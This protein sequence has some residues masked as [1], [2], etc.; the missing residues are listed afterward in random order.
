MFWP[1]KNQVI[2]LNTSKNVGFWGAHG[3]LY[4]GSNLYKYL[5]RNEHIDPK[6][7]FWVD[8]FWADTLSV[9]YLSSLEGTK[10][11][12]HTSIIYLV[13]TVRVPSFQP[14]PPPESCEM[15]L[16]EFEFQSDRGATWIFFPG[17]SN[18]REEVH[19]TKIDL[20]QLG[21][22]SGYGIFIYG[23]AYALQTT[24]C[25][26]HVMMVG[27]CKVICPTFPSFRHE[28]VSNPFFSAKYQKPRI[29]KIHLFCRDI[30]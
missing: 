10:I 13:Y 14:P 9:G 3:T 21:G 4:K 22:N 25:S 11:C 2:T 12:I 23:M 17:T 18:T 5:P 24:F 15:A 1:P 16:G 27:E 7:H 8:D 20:K 6:T 28:M 19:V 29:T 30:N 26:F